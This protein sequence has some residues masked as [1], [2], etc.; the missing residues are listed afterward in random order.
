M[1]EGSPDRLPRGNGS[2]ASM[3]FIDQF[4][5]S[6]STHR[7]TGLLVGQLDAFNRISATFGVDQSNEF[8]AEYAQQLRSILPPSTPVIRLPERRF[9]VLIALDS[10]TN[11]IDVAS[12]LGE[13]QAPQFRIGDD[14]FF[15]DLTLGVA[16]YPTHAEDATSLFRRAELALNEARAQELTFEIYRPDAT[17]QQAALWRFASELEQAV[18]DR[19]LEVH[20]Q[21]KVRVS[22]GGIVG[23]EALVRWRQESG[24]LVLPGEFIPLAEN[25]GS[26]IPIT[27]LVFDQ[28]VEIVKAWP[29]FDRAFSISVNVSAQVLGHMDF[30]V[31]TDALKAALDECGI[32]LILEL[33]EDSLV[34]N[35][36]ST[37]SRLNRIRKAGI[38]I[39]IDDFGKGYSSLTYL[40]DIPATEIKIDKKF[41]GTVASDKKDW[42]IIKAT[43]ELAHA[44]GMRVVAEGVDNNESLRVLDELG[45]EYAQ[46]FFIARP[47]RG[48]LLAEWAKGYEAASDAKLM[49]PEQAR[50]TANS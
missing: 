47:M 16:V 33:T 5:Q 21:P 28:I 27:W 13:D 36:N 32:D 18:Q 26:I 6:R 23:A 49:F 35:F 39:A 44:F 8:C 40:K 45:C 17:Q 25:S 19:A 29:P 15:V 31:K 50:L 42:H 43:M 12:Q 37:L 20:M 46:G 11:V 41:V 24:R 10:M 9:V 7:L 48:D 1:E 38:G 30:S 34:G 14:V 22:D 3:R 2:K 4:L